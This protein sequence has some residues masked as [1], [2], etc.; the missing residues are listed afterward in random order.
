M[1]PFEIDG[2]RYNCVEQY[3]QYTKAMTHNKLSRA[4]EIL[5]CSDPRRIKELGDGIEDNHDW[6]AIRVPTL[7]AG[8]SAK[9]QQNPDLA[10]ALISTGTQQLCE[11]TTDMFFG[12]GVGLQ[13]SKWSNMDW[14]GANVAGRIVMKVRSE[15]SGMNSS[16]VGV[17]PQG[18]LSD[19]TGLPAPLNE[20]QFETSHAS[21]DL[22]LND[23][24]PPASTSTPTPAKTAPEVEAS[25][26]NQRNWKKQYTKR[27][28]RGR[29]CGRGAGGPSHPP[30]PS[31]TS[32]SSNITDR[33]Y[34]R[35]SA[36]KPQLS[37]SDLEFLNMGNHM[38]T[39]Q[40]V[41]MEVTTSTP[42]SENPGCKQLSDSELNAMGID[43]GSE[44][45][46][47]VNRKYSVSWS[48]KQVI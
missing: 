15:L 37:K 35:Q 17:S 9:F 32:K 33:S 2:S 40:H 36:Q 5:N 7:Y 22:T 25:Q 26:R 18:D 41:D 27:G 1:Q 12:C 16:E 13:S 14:P 21:D 43:P 45:A 23:L 48:N 4:E 8:T 38:G 46:A 47:E 6:L 34:R 24:H 42:I 44:Y 20:S 10:I 31:N 30:N 3:Y 11:A 29:G 39:R 19:I 28:S